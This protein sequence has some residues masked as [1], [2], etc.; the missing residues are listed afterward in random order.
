MK[1]T[2]LCRRF[3]TS[4]VAR[5]PDAATLTQVY[6][7]LGV[8]LTELWKQMPLTDR[9]HSIAVMNRYSELRPDATIDELR[10]VLLHDVGKVQSSL[11]TGMRVIATIVGPRTS[12]FRDYHDHER[13]GANLV[14]AAGAS[15][16]TI[17]IVSGRALEPF[18]S[19]LRR[20]D[21]I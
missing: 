17:S 18:G 16:L 10:G 13:I 21:E 9:C 1:I 6:E 2:H 3:F 15:T 12:R 4:L 19:A 8:P 11:S 20:A 7:V 5:E 14:A